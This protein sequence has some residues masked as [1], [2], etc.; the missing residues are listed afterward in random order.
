MIFKP[1]DYQQVG[2]DKGIKFFD[3]KNKPA[4][5]VYGM[6]AGKSWIM[7]GIAKKLHEKRN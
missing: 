7:A 1:R 2:I 4:I 5:L 6:G 3:K